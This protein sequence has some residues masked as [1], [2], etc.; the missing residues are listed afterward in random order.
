MEALF[1]GINEYNYN[2]LLEIYK[3]QNDLIS[4]GLKKPETLKISE[5]E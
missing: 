1:E 2:L 4:K 5:E 3:V